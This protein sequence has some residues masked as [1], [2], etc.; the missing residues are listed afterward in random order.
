MSKKKPSVV[1][2]EK[3]KGRERDVEATILGGLGMGPTGG[4]GS[5]ERKYHTIFSLHPPPNARGGWVERL[6]H[7]EC[8]SSVSEVLSPE[9]FFS[10]S[11][12][13]GY[14]TIDRIK[15]GV[16]RKEGGMELR[17]RGFET[18][19]GDIFINGFGAIDFT[20]NPKTKRKTP[21]Q[22]YNPQAAWLF[23]SPNIDMSDQRTRR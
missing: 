16:G 1:P 22:C 17:E 10:F 15:S 23:K 14:R 18:D 21:W 7:R 9:C 11:F 12:R 13:W 6:T 20:P 5:G 8:R 3:I 2:Q 19:F 4:R